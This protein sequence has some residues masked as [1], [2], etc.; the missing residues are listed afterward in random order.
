MFFFGSP[1]DTATLMWDGALAEKGPQ[2]PDCHPE[3]MT[4]QELLNCLAYCRMAVE[5]ALAT[6]GMDHSAIEIL[7]NQFDQVFEIAVN[8]I[9]AFRANFVN[10]THVY[11]GGYATEN[12]NKYRALANLPPLAN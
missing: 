5:R 2:L 1:E 8:K 12:V 3:D 11:L 9:D 4:E 10:G 7:I 6:K